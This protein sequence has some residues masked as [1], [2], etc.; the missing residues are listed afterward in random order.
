MA[1]RGVVI[2]AGVA[3]CVTVFIA[4][5]VLFSSYMAAA[6]NVPLPPLP[7]GMTS[8]TQALNVVP[9]APPL[10]PTSIV[11]GLLL[12]AA[13]VVAVFLLVRS[14]VGIRAAG[15]AVAVGPLI[16]L[17]INLGAGVL[18]FVMGPADLR[19]QM[20]TGLLALQ[21]LSELIALAAPLIAV[22]VAAFWLRRRGV[23]SANEDSLSR[24]GASA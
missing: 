19:A 21:T 9:P 8:D 7:P 23:A 16:A 4:E 24:P 13:A 11:I 5:Q 2:V 10:L 20:F 17:A 3:S 15:L 1:G 12:S 18:D 14:G 22:V 6:L